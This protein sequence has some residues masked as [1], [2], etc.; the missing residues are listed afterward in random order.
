MNFVDL[1]LSGYDVF[2]PQRV[3]LLHGGGGDPYM[4]D[5]LGSSDSSFLNGIHI[6]NGLCALGVWYGQEQWEGAGRG[7]GPGAMLE[8]GLALEIH[9]TFFLTEYT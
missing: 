6:A 8:D 7:I 3:P 2:S 1:A 9:K 4:G 5:G